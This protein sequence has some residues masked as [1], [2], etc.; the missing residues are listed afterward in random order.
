MLCKI[1]TDGWLGE[2]VNYFLQ[3][4]KGMS[5]WDNC[6][7]IHPPYWHDASKEDIQ[8]GYR[9]FNI[10]TATMGFCVCVCVSSLNNKRI[11]ILEHE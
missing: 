7:L 4:E 3:H 6:A 10:W 1:G 5:F 9:I 2:K 8:A 11:L